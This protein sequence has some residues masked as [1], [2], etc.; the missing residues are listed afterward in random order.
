MPRF[1]AI[2]PLYNKADTINRAIASVL[3]QTIGESEIIVVDDGSTDGSVEKID[4]SYLPSISLVRQAN[5]WGFSTAT[6]NGGR[7]FWKRRSMRLT[8]MLTAPPM[9]PPIRRV[10]CRRC[11]RIYCCALSRDRDP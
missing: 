9:C 8:D 1:T 4:K 3:A 5:S 11:R 10:R 7:A 6:T 2:L